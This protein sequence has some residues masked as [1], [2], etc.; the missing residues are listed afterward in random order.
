[1]GT[2][3]GLSWAIAVQVNGEDLQTG[4]ALSYTP[5]PPFLI[6]IPPD[7]A[8]SP[9]NKN[10]RAFLINLPPLASCISSLLAAPSPAQEKGS[11]S[12]PWERMNSRL[13]HRVGFVHVGAAQHH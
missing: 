5:F 11:L 9:G 1:M 10:T 7:I 12:L 13:V 6:A 8:G 4:P 2:R 3:A